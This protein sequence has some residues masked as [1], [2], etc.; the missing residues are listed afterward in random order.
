[1][2]KEQDRKLIEKIRQ[3]DEKAFEVIFHRF[4]P[5]LCSFA[6][7]FTKDDNIAEEIVQDLFIRL[8][9]KKSFISI[10]FSLENYLLKAVKNQCINFLEQK[11]VQQ[12]KID[13]YLA[14]NKTNQSD[15]FSF[16][17]LDLIHKIEES[18][19]SLP[20]KRREI[21][22]LSREEGLKYSEI[23]DVMNISIKTV[24]TQMG[25]ALKTLRKKLKGL[26]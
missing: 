25:L 13:D 10:E 8:W 4:Y 26:I 14:E 18:I 2:I 1:M 9:E 24:E 3:G 15:D 7:Q 19:A 23:A 22:L 17:D 11:K 6:A 5:V 12:K 21:F 20:K 16:F